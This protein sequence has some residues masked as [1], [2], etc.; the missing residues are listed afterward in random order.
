MQNEKEVFDAVHANLST[1]TL[2]AA[3]E[4]GLSQNALWHTLHEEQL[5]LVHV[6]LEQGLQP[7]DSNFHLLFC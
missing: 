5:Y 7:G 6:Q 2:Q 3:Y 1:S 4:T